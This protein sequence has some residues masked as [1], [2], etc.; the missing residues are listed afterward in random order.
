M[1][2]LKKI[3]FPKLVVTISFSKEI[4]ESMNAQLDQERREKEAFQ[5]QVEEINIALSEARA[6]VDFLQ[7]AVQA[8]SRVGHIPGLH[9]DGHSLL[10]EIEDRRQELESKHSSLQEKH[11]GLLQT[12]QVE[13]RRLKSRIQQLSQNNGSDRLESTQRQLE[14]RL[15]QVLNENKQLQEQILVL[16]KRSDD[17]SCDGQGNGG[18]R[19]DSAEWEQRLR[20]ASL[21]GNR[22]ILASEE[23]KNIVTG[24]GALLALS[25][26]VHDVTNELARTKRELRTATMLK[27]SETER[28]YQTERKL[29][30]AEA[31]LERSHRT[32]AQLR[33]QLQD[34]ASLA[35]SATT[36]TTTTTTPAS[37]PAVPL[38]STAKA[39]N[40]EN[41]PVIVAAVPIKAPEQAP[42]HVEAPSK[43][44]LQKEQVEAPVK[45]KVAPM[46]VPQPGQPKQVVV[47]RE[48]VNE[49][50]Q[51]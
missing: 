42:E 25:Q 30:E 28:L 39:T 41:T 9:E 23:V 45:P 51:Q 48:N 18:G 10:S 36:T 5:F 31:Q 24:E 32:I 50:A 43:P 1:Q 12:H 44:Q 8:E 29:Q 21:G 6:T 7:K 15:A 33:F 3:F 19:I 40:K 11:Q 27:A 16:K 4:F 49:C 14:S 34:P 47:K 2:V 46:P 13:Q 35:S 38:Q 37:T 20:H 22:S 17:C 26:Q